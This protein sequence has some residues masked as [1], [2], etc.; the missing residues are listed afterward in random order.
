MGMTQ[1]EQQM[2]L[3]MPT[4]FS[5]VSDPNFSA[6]VTGGPVVGTSDLLSSF[7]G[8]GP[9]MAEL[10]GG[11]VLLPTPGSYMDPS[12][13]CAATYAALA[14]TPMAAHFAQLASSRS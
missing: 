9:M 7:G 8:L 4:G 12:N 11:Q 3:Q 10:A 1:E 2:V 13:A 14:G 6:G 5:V